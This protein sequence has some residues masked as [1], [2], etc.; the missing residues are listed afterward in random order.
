MTLKSLLNKLLNRYT[1]KVSLAAGLSEGVR[2]YCIGDIHGRL[3]LLNDAHSKIT[4]HLTDYAGQSYVVYLGDYIDRGPHSMQVVDCLINTPLTNAIAVYLLGNH[5]QIMLQFM[6]NADMGLAHE[7]FRFGGLATLQSYGVTLKGIPTNKDIDDIRADLNEK[8]PLSHKQFYQ[9][10][11]THFELDGY[12][13]VHAGIKP[14]VKLAKQ[15][16]DDLLWIREEFLSSTRQHG[17]VIVHGHSVSEVPEILP[18]RVGLDTGA[19]ASNILTCAVFEG[20]DIT[21]L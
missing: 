10:L 18:N 12:Y 9:T 17:K 15:N 21:I 2:V 13:F 14:K 11:V 5:E 19:Y 1:K 16:V 3:D 6:Y 8:C 4:T 20:S 7:W